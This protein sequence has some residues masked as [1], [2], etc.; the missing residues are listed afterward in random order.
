M[1]YI[2]K[3]ALRAFL[4]AGIICGLLLAS[5]TLV[6]QTA[7]PGEKY[8]LF[9]SDKQ[10]RQLSKASEIQASVKAAL[11]E[12]ALQRRLKVRDADNLIDEDDFPV[13]GIYLQRLAD[14]GYQPVVVSKWLNAASFVLLQADLARITALPFVDKIVPVAKSVRRPEPSPAHIPSLRKSTDARA[15]VNYGSSFSQNSVIR[16]TDVH[17]LGISGHGIWIGMLDTGFRY[18]NHEVFENMTVLAERDFINGDGIT[19]NQDGDPAN[20]DRHGTQTLSVIGGFKEGQLI[21]PAFSASYFLAKTEDESQEVRAE[22]DYWIAGIEWLESQG[23]DVA[24][25]SLG[26]ID[27]YTPDNM[28]GKTAPITIAADKAVSRGVVVVVSAGNEGNVPWKVVS[29]PADGFDVI[30]VGA[31]TSANTIAGFSSRGPTA[32]GRTKPEV[33]AMGISAYAATPSS[34][35]LQNTYSFVSGTSFSCPS[36]AG[37]AALLLS[38]HPRLTPAEVREALLATADRAGSP[39]NE[40]GWG[41]VNA[42]EAVLYH[43]AAFSNK[44]TALINQGNNL[45]IAL[46]VASK[47]G[48]AD[49]GVSL[50]YSSTGNN[51]TELPMGRGPDTDQFVTAVPEQ[52]GTDTI[53]YYFRMSDLAGMAAVHP[54]EAPDLWF[55]YPEDPRVY[56]PRHS[57]VPETFSLRQNFPNPFNPSTT[58]RFDLPQAA[59]VTLVVYNMLGQ[60]ITTLLAEQPMFAGQHNVVWNGEDRSGKSAASGVYFYNLRTAGTSETKKMLLLR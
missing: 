33:M 19:E 40:Y 45:E 35:K 2:A 34:D 20:E 37:V 16:V 31:V 18:R 58:I 12:R 41:L 11:T 23:I 26:Y 25:S 46:K 15:L 51:F 48:I 8:W 5:A 24:S 32:D 30:A 13:S 27:W 39:D 3:L 55:S 54:F 42:Y 59:T 14:M 17:D 10:V 36:T 29:A 47:A 52:V 56:S 1:I 28:D 22:E 60:N 50:F 9:F 4:G 7:S 53:R 44:P 57:T 49:D 38:A 43:G 6:A 21:G